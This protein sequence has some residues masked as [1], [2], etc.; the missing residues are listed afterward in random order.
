MQRLSDLHVHWGHLG[1]LITTRL[2]SPHSKNFW[3][4]WLEQSLW[5]F[6]HFFEQA[7]SGDS[8]TSGSQT[9]LGV[10]LV[11]ALNFLLVSFKFNPRSKRVAT[12]YLV[13]LCVSMLIPRKGM[14]ESECLICMW[15]GVD[16][17]GILISLRKKSQLHSSAPPAFLSQACRPLKKACREAL[18]EVFSLWNL[19]FSW[20]MRT[21]KANR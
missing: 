18:W 9:T 11:R 3:W 8:A 10:T 12:V 7:F 20:G 14:R 13:G 6:I 19:I 4:Y 2:L 21:C 16:R 1:N 15:V 5:N 17:G